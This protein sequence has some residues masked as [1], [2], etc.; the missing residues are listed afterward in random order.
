MAIDTANLTG[1]RAKLGR[2]YVHLNSL[3]DELVQLNRAHAD[4]SF[5]EFGRDGEWYTVFINPISKFP[6]ELSLIAGDI[7]TNLRDTLD[8]IVWQLILR[9]GNEPQ[10]T[11]DF[12]IITSESRFMKVV[13]TPPKKTEK[14]SPLYGLPVDGDAWAII[15]EAQPWYR[16][17]ANGHEA[18]KDILATLALMSNI[19]K[20]RTVLTSLAVP[21]QPMLEQMLRWTPANVQPIEL[22]LPAWKALSHEEPTELVRF[23]FP[24][25]TDIRMYMNGSYPIS[26]V[27]GD[28][29]TQTGGLGSFCER[30]SEI[31]GQVGSLPRVDG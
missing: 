19:N 12:P 21:D 6:I 7:F 8:H 3:K 11:N 29:N 28:E 23:L 5:I 9:E 17:K 22:I 20:H 31:V 18:K 25:G 24:T 30:F 26:P 1:V 4:T 10:Q 15:E 2:A 16:G 27:F 13:K 14:R